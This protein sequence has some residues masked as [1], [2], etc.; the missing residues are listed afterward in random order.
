MSIDIHYDFHKRH[1]LPED[2]IL[3][4]KRI[5]IIGKDLVQHG[6][7]FYTSKV[8]HP[9]FDGYGRIFIELFDTNAERTKLLTFLFDPEGNS[10]HAIQDRKSTEKTKENECTREWIK[11]FCKNHA[12]LRKADCVSR[13]ISS[14]PKAPGEF[15]VYRHLFNDGRI[16]IGKGKGSRDKAKSGR[17]FYYSRTLKEAGEP[18]IERLC[19]EISED[20]AYKIESELI[21]EFRLHY[22]Y[23]FVINR[24]EGME[25]EKDR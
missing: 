12:E 25:K 13:V 1:Y 22:G 11:E 2:V 18:Q 6:V 4:G 8:N 21:K 5:T 19:D 10:L 3:A 16:Y 20:A 23:S 9:S 24:T 14:T 7:G 17:G 15:Y